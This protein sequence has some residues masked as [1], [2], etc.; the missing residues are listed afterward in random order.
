MQTSAVGKLADAG[1][2][3]LV[4]AREVVLLAAI[5]IVTATVLSELTT[6][7]L[8]WFA[9]DDELRYERLAISIARTHSLVPRIHDVNIE[10]YSQ[11]YPLLIA[12]FFR[13]GLVPD[14]VRTVHLANAWIMSSACIPAFFLA[15]RVTGRAWAGYVSA[16][17]A[18]VMPW[19]VLS[20]MM[21]T[22][23][24]SYPAS[25]WAVYAIQR[26]TVSPS[27]RNDLFAL[28]AIAVAYLARGELLVLLVV[29]PLAVLG[30]ELRG[31][32]RS[33]RRV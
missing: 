10:S 18:V 21:M 25:V 29:F 28:V 3:L 32:E 12:P 22:E 9:K 31:G 27:R 13:H 23:V 1:T 5:W 16:A 8:D 24:A 6:R 7:A 20:A 11:L 14:N 4:R 17:L 2:A 26:A 19:I 33:A 30:Y 15:R